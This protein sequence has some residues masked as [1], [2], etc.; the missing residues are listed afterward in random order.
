[1]SRIAVAHFP[2]ARR[3]FSPGRAA[4]ILFGLGL[5]LAGLF[6]LGCLAGA[7]S[8]DLSR[9]LREPG[10][11]DGRILFGLR[12]P[13][14]ALAAI[15]GMGLAAAG[16]AYQGLLR[17]P[18][19]DPFI[20]GVSGGAALGGTLALALGASFFALG[21]SRGMVA[22]FAASGAALATALAFVAGKRSGQLDP[23][24]TLLAGVIFNSFAASLV[25]V[26]KTLVAPE[27]AQ[28]LL[29][30]L[31][32][33]I[34][35]ESGRTLLFAAI[36][37]L[38]PT[39]LLSTQGHALNLLALGDEG[40][41]SLGVD[42]ARLRNTVFFASSVVVGIAVSLT[43]LVAFV[44]LLVP[45]LLRLAFGADHRLLIPASA[46]GGAIFLV[47]ADLG[48]RL[49]F[50]LLGTEL[51]AGALTALAGGPFFLFLFLRR[52]GV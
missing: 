13:R 12:L 20:L 51:P 32:G 52:Q 38:L 28:Q 35:Y 45:H 2:L 39:A 36:G 22:V 26:L 33:S 49:L 46:L 27:T 11:L 47:A 17:N 7:E 19:A 48:A 10:S 30:W 40:A 41:A 23:V 18:L 43:G 3:T 25:T 42:V 44:G 6:V 1:M 34:G 8:I 15:T 14:L 16:A 5:L 37:T 21:A 9:A 4:V 31:T 24:R 50:P 29:F